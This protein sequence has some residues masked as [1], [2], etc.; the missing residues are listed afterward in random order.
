MQPPS[1]K[2][3]QLEAFLATEEFLERLIVEHSNAPRPAAAA[4]PQPTDPLQ[5]RESLEA[6]SRCGM[7]ESPVT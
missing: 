6:V 2:F 7:E 4:E 5:R 3:L 1:Q